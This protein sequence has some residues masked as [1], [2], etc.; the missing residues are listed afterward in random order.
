MME[1]NN[2][3]KGIIFIIIAIVIVVLGAWYFGGGMNTQDKNAETGDVSENGD[4]NVE[5]DSTSVSYPTKT[6]APK[7]TPTGSIQINQTTDKDGIILIRYTDSGFIPSVL[8]LNAGDTVRFSNMSSKPMWVTTRNHP[9]FVGDQGYR[10]FDQGKSVSTGGE[11]LFTF[12]KIGLWQYKN[13]NDDSH[14][15]IITVLPQ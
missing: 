11:Y 5:S 8:D 2:S 3:N 15:G 12:T 14:L 7:V 4:I 10:E 9:N 6:S 1:N 13:L